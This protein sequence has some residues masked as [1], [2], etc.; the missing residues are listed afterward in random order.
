MKIQLNKLVA[1]TILMA[2]PFILSATA[3]AAETVLVNK[4]G[5]TLYTFDI[6]SDGLSYCNDGCAKKWPPYI[7][8]D[9][10]SVKKGY[11]FTVRDDGAKQWT[12]D[13][14]PLYTW[15]G[16]VKKGDMTGDG[17]GGVWHVAKKQG[18]SY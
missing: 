8:K 9:G 15:I 17:I 10:A 18:Y 7:M 16:D 1:G 2:S 4:D 6:D 11:G 5:M 12:Y 3:V 14:K 13:N